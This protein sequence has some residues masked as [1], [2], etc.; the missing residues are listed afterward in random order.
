MK[1]YYEDDMVTLYHGSCLDITEWVV[2]DVLVTDPPYGMSFQSNKRKKN[3]RLAAIAGD[4]DPKLRDS[5]IAL[6]GSER[7]AIVFGTWR[8]P[9]P[10]GERQRLIWAKLGSVG[11]GDLSMPWGTSHE[12]IHVLGKGWNREATG[13]KRMGSVIN[14]TQGGGGAHGAANATGH[15]TPKPVPLMENLIQRCP[16]GVIAEPF[17]GSGATLVAAR[18][19]GRKAIGVE[20]EERYCEGIANRL[21]QGSLIF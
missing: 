15:P 16:P 9:P 7:P 13:Q 5:A 2:A 19:L 21:A 8:V 18:N 4:A 20:L 6:W 17:A 10:A 3:E 11:M 12:D 14:G 1:P